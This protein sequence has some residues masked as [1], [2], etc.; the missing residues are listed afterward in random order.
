MLFNWT[1]QNFVIKPRCDLLWRN[2]VEMQ[3]CSETM[4]NASRSGF[5]VM[6]TDNWGYKNFVTFGIR[7]APTYWTVRPRI[8]LDMEQCHWNGI[9]AMTISED[10]ELCATS[11]C[12]I[13]RKIQDFAIHHSN[14]VLKRTN[15]R[16]PVY[17]FTTTTTSNFK[18][19]H[20]EL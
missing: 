16:S 18:M 11:S 2:A 7:N 14:G 17:N 13:I 1:W 6:K 9:L 5:V 19:P 12:S 3:C 15:I 10:D 20:K 4:C 8:A